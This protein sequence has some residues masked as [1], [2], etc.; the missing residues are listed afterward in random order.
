MALMANTGGETMSII[1][2][3]DLTTNII[4]VRDANG[5]M[6]A[7]VPV[8]SYAML[9][10]YSGSSFSLYGIDDN[11]AMGWK[12]PDDIDTDGYFN[13]NGY[14][15]LLSE[16]G[17]NLSADIYLNDDAGFHIPPNIYNITDQT[18]VEMTD[19]DGIVSTQ[20]FFT[21]HYALL[22]EFQNSTD[23]AL[24]QVEVTQND[25]GTTSYTIPDD[26]IPINVPFSLFA[27]PSSDFN[28]DIS[29]AFAV[30]SQ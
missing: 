26:G 17:N 23:M 14:G 13:N 4:E 8:G 5:F 2:L 28:G 10:D 29:K 12:F 21:G 27:D 6:G 20:T 22:P 16:L 7:N 9:F 25:D 19:A 30:S 18:V 24:Y 11:G 1:S 3:Q 15:F